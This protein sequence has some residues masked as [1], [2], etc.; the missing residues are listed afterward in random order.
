ME[1]PKPCVTGC[2]QHGRHSPDCG[3][4][5]CRGDCCC[6]ASTGPWRLSCDVQGVGEGCGPAVP[7]ED[8]KGCEPWPATR[9]KVCG[10]CVSRLVSGLSTAAELVVHIRRQRTP[11][12]I[13]GEKAQKLGTSLIHVGKK[14]APPVPLELGAV[15]DADR[16]YVALRDWTEIIAD[17][18]GMVGPEPQ[19]AWRTI[20]GKVAGLHPESDGSE[21][22]PYATWLLRHLDGILDLD[23]V[24]VMVGPEGLT[25]VIHGAARRWPME[26]RDTFMPG[27]FCPGCDR[28]TM[29]RYPP[30]RPGD[31]VIVR[32]TSDGCGYATTVEALEVAS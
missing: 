22:G 3:V 31:D 14:P 17:G 2:T 6:H 7:A 4:C 26:D 1:V 21:A 25:R 28:R 5:A 27:T 12:A 8:C 24:A 20:L 18:L 19:R 23:D 30:E 29:R 9:G 10:R 11:G 32:C 13:Q 16:I 15:D